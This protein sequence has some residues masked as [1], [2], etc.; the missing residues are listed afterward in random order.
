LG[1][2]LAVVLISEEVDYE[3]NNFFDDKHNR[4]EIEQ[5][6]DAEHGVHLQEEGEVDEEVADCNSRASVINKVHN[7]V[8]AGKSAA[9]RDRR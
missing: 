8:S 1:D 4:K 9:T 5:L 6:R 7:A 2:H 3:I